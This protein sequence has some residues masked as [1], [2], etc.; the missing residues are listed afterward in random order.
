MHGKTDGRFKQSTEFE[1]INAM[2]D[3]LQSLS[4]ERI[5]ILKLQDSLSKGLKGDI[6]DFM[7]SFRC[8]QEKSFFF[9]QI[10]QTGSNFRFGLV[11]D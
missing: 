10:L 4:D 9:Q 3:E 7:T 1:S 2:R 6:R 5:A 8:N 11:Q